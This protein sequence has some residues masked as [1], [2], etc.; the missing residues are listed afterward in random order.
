MKLLIYKV[1]INDSEIKFKFPRKIISYANSDCLNYSLKV[2][3]CIQYSVRYPLF[4][5]QIIQ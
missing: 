5:T 3:S 4:N 2:S 1:D